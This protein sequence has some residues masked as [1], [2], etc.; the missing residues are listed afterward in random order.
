MS[1]WRFCMRFGFMSFY[2]KNKQKTVKLLVSTLSAS[3]GSPSWAVPLLFLFCC[4]TKAG[5]PK[6]PMSSAVRRF[7]DVPRPG[8]QDG[9]PRVSWASGVRLRWRTSGS[10]SS[11][12]WGERA[13]SRPLSFPL[14]LGR[15]GLAA[16][17]A[18]RGLP[19]QPPTE[20]G[21]MAQQQPLPAW[22]GGSWP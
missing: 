3:L 17:Q 7:S 10:L 15:A 20:R 4:P 22:G 9:P 6:S 12:G 5:N 11:Q 14:G 1:S 19:R 13:T 16:G 2:C 18:R 8:L 21:L